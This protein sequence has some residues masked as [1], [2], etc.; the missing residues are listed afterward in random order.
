[1]GVS[2]GITGATGFGRGLGI[3]ESLGSPLVAAVTTATTLIFS[4][5]AELSTS[6][7]WVIDEALRQG[8][9]VSR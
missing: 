5:L 1:V 4:R 7:F 2:V 3:S 9:V 6:A 8:V